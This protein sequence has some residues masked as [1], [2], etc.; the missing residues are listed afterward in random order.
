MGILS[1]IGRVGGAVLGSSKIPLVSGIGS[2]I[3]NMASQSQSY[4]YQERLLEKQQKFAAEQAEID[5]KWNS[6]PEQAKRLTEAGVNPFFAL[7]GATPSTVQS[8]SGGSAPSSPVGSD[9]GS[10]LGQRA[11]Q[12]SLE[13]QNVEADIDLKRSQEQLNSEDAKT[14]HQQNLVSMLLDFNK[15][16]FISQEKA[17]SVSRQLLNQQSYDFN[18]VYNEK[19][20]ESITLDN[21]FKSINNQIADFNLKHLDERFKMEMASTRAQIARDF[22]SAANLNAEINLYKAQSFHFSELGWQTMQNIRQNHMTDD[23]AKRY[24]ESTVQ[25]IEGNAKKALSQ[26]DTSYWKETGQILSSFL[27]GFVGI[28]SLGFL[29]KAKNA[30]KAYKAGRDAAKKSK[31]LNDG[32]K[33]YKT[34]QEALYGVD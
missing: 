12:L 14:R 8:Q 29:S 22:A 21:Q 32:V 34:S 25:E 15:A 4:E 23:Q 11:Q 7:S 20:I 18:S 10:Q 1:S 5:R 26:G 2:S 17:E 3:E 31:A 24:I 13:R 19:Q 28:K 30:V 16:G 9:V 6:A 33:T 27:M